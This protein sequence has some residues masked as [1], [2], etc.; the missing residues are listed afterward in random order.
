M[1]KD[2]DKNNESEKKERMAPKDKEHLTKNR[3]NLNNELMR[4]WGF[5]KKDKKH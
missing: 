3:E 5:E 4:R 2:K 1:S